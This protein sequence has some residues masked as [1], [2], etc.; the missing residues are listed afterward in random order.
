MQTVSKILTLAAASAAL[1]LGVLAT[2]PASAFNSPFD[3]QR[4]VLS[5]Q[6]WVDY[7]E[8]AY[9]GPRGYDRPY[10]YDLPAY[11]VR[12]GAIAICPP[13]YHLGR[14]GALCWPN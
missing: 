14:G 9:Q 12:S 3:D 13:G 2:T 7:D 4:N 6:G 1:G 8:D 5:H 10:D 11:G